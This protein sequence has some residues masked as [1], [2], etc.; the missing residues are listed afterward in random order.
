MDRRSLSLTI[1]LASL[2]AVTTAQTAAPSAVVKTYCVSCH[3]G[4]APKGNVSMDRAD[5]DNPA[6]DPET[7]ERVVR[8]LRARTMPVMGAPRPNDTVYESTIAEL[9]NAIDGAAIARRPPTDR[10]IASRL[11]RLI[12]NTDPD[13][14]LADATSRGHL[15]DPDV[16]QAQVR[17]MLADS[18]S[19]AL[20]TGFF[21]AWLSLDDLKTMKS[22]SA[23]F[24]EFD[25]ELRAAMRRETE[26]FIASQL[27]DDRSPRDLWSAD[28]TF[29]NERLARHYGVPAVSGPEYRRVTW[30][31]GERA[32]LLGQ[33]S[34]LTLTSYLFNAYPVDVPTTSPAQRSKWILTRAL[35]VSPPAT[36]QNVPSPDFPFVKGTPLVEQSRSFP[37]TPCLACHRAFFPLSYGLENFDVL[38]RWRADYGPGA[39]N[40]S[41]TMVDGTAFNGPIQLRQALLAREDA[42][43]N[44]LTEKLLAYAV[45]GP[46]A[47]HEPAPPSRMPIVRGV[48]RESKTQNHSWSALI[49]AIARASY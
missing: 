37:A 30:P 6:K 35:G 33:G 4:P 14:S 26:L 1:V 18:K 22:D 20:V 34:I 8:H 24:P 13:Q 49:A 43:L 44:A 21:G 7:W 47:I 40:A 15:R 48:L 3:S 17:R 36:V 38:G 45:G 28:Y 31:R 11:S 39:I 12:W 23:L 41:G 10:E 5:A 9:T 27:R 19:S 16:L 32:G 29:V 25:D 42:F 2:P 46:S